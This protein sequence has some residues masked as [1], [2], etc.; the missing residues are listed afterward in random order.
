MSINVNV[1]LELVGLVSFTD[2]VRCWDRN[3][4]ISMSYNA[5][6]TPKSANPDRMANWRIILA[7][8]CMQWRHQ[9]TWP[10]LPWTCIMVWLR[11]VSIGLV[12]TA[13]DYGTGDPRKISGAVHFLC[14]WSFFKFFLLYFL[15]DPV[16]FKCFL[17]FFVCTLGGL[18]QGVINRWYLVIEVLMQKT[19]FPHLIAKRYTISPTGPVNIYRKLMIYG[20]LLSFFLCFG[21]R[22]SGKSGAKGLNVIKPTRSCLSDQSKGTIKL[23]S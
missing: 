4:A 12:D 3:L 9:W 10:S 19:L 8:S 13:L 21:R 2:R 14:T 1:F 16:I 5:F 6:S 7:V 17:Q 22:S 18:G 20:F 23:L 11:Q 15:G